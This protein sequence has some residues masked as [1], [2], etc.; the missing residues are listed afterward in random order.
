[1]NSYEYLQEKARKD[2]VH[3]IDYHFDSNQIRGLYCNGT[4][5]IRQ[6]MT[7]AESSCRVSWPAGSA[8]LCRR[9]AGYVF[10][11][12]PTDISLWTV[13]S[14]ISDRLQR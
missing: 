13:L 11:I 6:N 12:S 1:M 10:V 2:G 7:T 4:V 14:L 3:V 5:A 9:S 8:T